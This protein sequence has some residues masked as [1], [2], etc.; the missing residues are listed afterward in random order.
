MGNKFVNGKPFFPEWFTLIV[1]WVFATML[2]IGALLL[3][4]FVYL[5]TAPIE[6]LRQL[7]LR[8]KG[9]RDPTTFRRW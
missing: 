4:G 7:W 5:A 6:G 9:W 3:G 8:Y 1:L 2:L